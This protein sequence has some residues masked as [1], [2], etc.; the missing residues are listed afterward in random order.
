MKS[1]IEYLY[2][3]LSVSKSMLY[4][5]INAVLKT[6]TTLLAKLISQ[7]HDNADDTPWINTYFKPDIKVKPC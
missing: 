6:V 7:L 5:P 2:V 3:Y 4:K 1:T